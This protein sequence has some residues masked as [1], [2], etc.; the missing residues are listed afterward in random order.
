M[1]LSVFNAHDFVPL[2]AEI[3]LGSLIM[4]AKLRRPY[5]ATKSQ[6]KCG[7]IVGVTCGPGTCASEWPGGPDYEDGCH[8]PQTAQQSD[9]VSDDVA[10]MSAKLLGPLDI[11]IPSEPDGSFV[12]P[13]AQ[14]ST[15][16]HLFGK[17]AGNLCALNGPFS[18]TWANPSKQTVISELYDW[19]DDTGC[20]S[21]GLA[22]GKRKCVYPDLCAPSLNTRVTYQSPEV[23]EELTIQKAPDT[24]MIQM[25]VSQVEPGPVTPTLITWDGAFSYTTKSAVASGLPTKR[26]VPFD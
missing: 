21:A 18:Y 2:R 26:Y 9:V 25:I 20:S 8:S 13:S 1:N 16:L 14:G 23:V 15:T 5:L 11:E 19:R 4:R 17:F 22:K 7:G 24:P 6:N 12:I 3:T 10:G